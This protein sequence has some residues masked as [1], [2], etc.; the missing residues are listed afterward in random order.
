M[1]GIGAMIVGSTPQAFGEWIQEDLK[2]WKK[3]VQE[4]KVP[5]Q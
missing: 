4:A 5:Q 1:K 3:V 2:R